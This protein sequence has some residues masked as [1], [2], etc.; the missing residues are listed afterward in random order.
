M[1]AIQWSMV[2]IQWTAISG[3]LLSE[4]IFVALLLMPWINPK[5][6]HAFFNS[7]LVQRI[8]HW[9]YTKAG[10]H[11]V[12]AM[13]IVFLFDAIRSMYVYGQTKE[14][15]ATAPVMSTADKDALV[16]M[17]MF[18]AERNFFIVAFTLFFGVLLKRLITL[19]CL[20]AELIAQAEGSTIVVEK[21]IREQSSP[22][23]RVLEKLTKDE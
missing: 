21:P 15:Q 23:K 3:M 20:E 2:N 14:E 10:A 22:V 9:K 18:R 6:W 19:I 5:F 13:L 12:G 17:R 11:V 7:K 4:M 8:L 16:N 1:F